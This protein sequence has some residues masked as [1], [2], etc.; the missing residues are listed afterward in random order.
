MYLKIAKDFSQYPGS[1]SRKNSDNSAEQLYEEILKPSIQKC[2]EKDE[3]L[4]IDLDGS[5]GYA[6]SFIDEAFG[7]IIIDF[8][9]KD[10]DYENSFNSRIKIISNE[11]PYL[12]QDIIKSINEWWLC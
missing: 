6:S 2:I 11:E 9:C 8:Y 3:I 1:R 4:T 10:Y 5:S 7:R 12:I